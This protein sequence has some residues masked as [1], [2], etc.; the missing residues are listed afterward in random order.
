MDKDSF[1]GLCEVNWII[2]P[3]KHKKMLKSYNENTT[4]LSLMVQIRMQLQYLK[5]CLGNL[6]WDF[7]ICLEESMASNT[8]IGQ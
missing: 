1:W 5:Y 8:K 3:K 2:L 4:V 7:G 6:I